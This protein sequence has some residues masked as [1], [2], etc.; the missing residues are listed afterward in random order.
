MNR[1]TLIRKVVSKLDSNW[2]Q[3]LMSLNERLEKEIP[4]AK[5]KE[6][7][8]FLSDL[9]LSLD[10]DKHEFFRY[11]NNHIKSFIGDTKSNSE[12]KV[13][14][15]ELISILKPIAKEYDFENKITLDANDIDWS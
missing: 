4:K 11:V 3:K 1:S 5:S 9:S 2:Q 8:D 7:K 14:F 12:K 15:N 10:D 6:V 13:L